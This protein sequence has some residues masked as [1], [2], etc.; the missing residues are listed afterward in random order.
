[1]IDA[2]DFDEI[3]AEYI[4]KASIRSEHLYQIFACMKR[5]ATKVVRVDGVLPYPRDTQPLPCY[6][7]RG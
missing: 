3:L 7:G 4:R 5:L 6:A 2:K 1:V